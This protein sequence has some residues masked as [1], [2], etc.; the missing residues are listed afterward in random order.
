MH[1]LFQAP[2]RPQCLMD[3]RLRP[4][5]ASFRPYSHLVAANVAPNLICSVVSQG[6]RACTLLIIINKRAAGTGLL[7]FAPVTSPTLCLAVVCLARLPVL[8]RGRPGIMSCLLSAQLTIALVAHG[9]IMGGG[10]RSPPVLRGCFHSP[11]H[12]PAFPR[13]SSASGANSIQLGVSWS[14]LVYVLFWSSPPV[15]AAADALLVSTS[16][17]GRSVGA[18]GAP[19]L[20]WRRSNS[21]LSTLAPA[22]P[23]E[24]LSLRWHSGVPLF[25]RGRGMLSRRHTL[26]CTVMTDMSGISM[27]FWRLRLCLILSL[28][29]MM[30]D[31]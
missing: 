13:T 2:T 14:V 15:A 23:R 31:S 27:C 11:F 6:A 19:L 8:G 4:Q 22:W 18:D 3:G 28:G 5:T 30:I 7:I 16:T 17:K 24:L 9:D 21:L 10:P 1:P 20:I 26:L 25:L 12:P 29:I